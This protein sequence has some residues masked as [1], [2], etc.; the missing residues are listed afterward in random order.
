MCKGPRLERKPAAS[1]RR[2]EPPPSSSPPSPLPVQLAVASLLREPPG[3][4][5]LPTAEELEEPVGRMLG[6]GPQGALAGGGGGRGAGRGADTIAGGAV[7]RVAGGGIQ[8]GRARS[9][10]G[11][12]VGPGWCLCSHPGFIA[13]ISRRRKPRQGAWRAGVREEWVWGCQIP[14]PGLSQDPAS[15]S[16]PKL[17]SSDRQCSLGPGGGRRRQGLGLWLGAGTLTLAHVLR[18]S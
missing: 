5:S 15:G 10:P 17:R 2:K 14:P 9:A 8:A 11:H 1:R 3:A 13:P 18:F 16:F 12:R 4:R 7:A 6:W